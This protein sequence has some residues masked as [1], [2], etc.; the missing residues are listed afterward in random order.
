[1]IRVSPI[2]LVLGS[3]LSVQAGAAIAK[4]LFG[5][6]GPDAMV[7]LRLATSTLVFLVII[8]PRIRGHTSRDWLTVIGYGG[9]L[10]LM[11]WAIYQSFARIP[12]GLAVTLEFL[13]PLAVAVAASRSA[14]D[15]LWAGLAGLGVGLLGFGPRMLDPWGVMFALLAGAG[16][17]GYILTSRAVGQRWDGLSGLAVSSALATVIVTGPVLA[18]EPGDLWRPDVILVGA[19]IGLLSSV[20]PYSLELMA[21]RRLPPRV[22]GILMSL[23]PAAAALAALLLLG[24]RLSTFELMAMLCVVAA[25]AGATRTVG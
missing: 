21:L 8:R 24:E 6:V 13:G 1:M 16:W 7:W 2:W 19:A 18:G 14:R 25:S 17:A 11:N 23:E 3:I 4:S 10:A 15:L 9:S 5:Q 22:F 20:V 12:L